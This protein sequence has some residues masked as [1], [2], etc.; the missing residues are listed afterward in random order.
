MSSGG[1][2][3]LGM[4]EELIGQQDLTFVVRENLAPVPAEAAGHLVVEPY[5]V[6]PC[7]ITNGCREA[8]TRSASEGVRAYDRI[9][10][11]RI[12]RTCLRTSVG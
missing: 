8:R 2:L 11:R 4:A 5:A 1:A 9:E 3:L 6:R 7:A 12:R 10:L